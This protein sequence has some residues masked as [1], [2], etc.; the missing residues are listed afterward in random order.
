[1]LDPDGKILS[2][3]AVAARLIGYEAAEIIGRPFAS[4]S[5]KA[6]WLVRKDNSRFPAQ[7]I[8]EP[9]LGDAGEVVG[10][11]ATLH[12]G[13]ANEELENRVE[14]RIRDLNAAN[15]DLQ[16]LA[17]TDELTGIFNLRGFLAAAGQELARAARYKRPL[18]LLYLDID[19]FK[20]V[21]D[22]F[23]HAAG[24]RALK[25]VVK[26]MS[27][28]LREGDIIARIGGDEF[29]M[30]LRESTPDEAAYVAERICEAV[31]S[32]TTQ[33]VGATFTT[34]VSVGVA[35][36]SP[37]E[38][39]DHLLARADAALYAVKSVKKNQMAE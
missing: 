8:I 16:H 10:L 39:I 21:N 17:D 7:I 24:D 11:A 30:L 36:W 4:L 14:E 5:A 22:T 26:E 31:I 3:T 13:E 25:M 2:C 20:A 38:L 33:A 12:P 37:P 15:A 28:Q 29:V 35:R 19:K 6:G 23:G 27:R 1:M 34:A 18:C 9:L 32:A